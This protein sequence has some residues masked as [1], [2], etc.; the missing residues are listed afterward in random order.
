MSGGKNKIIFFVNFKRKNIFK[1]CKQTCE[2]M[3]YQGDNIAFN[4]AE[5]HADIRPVGLFFF[6]KRNY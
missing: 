3:F 6:P 4:E 5:Q 1:T 2:L